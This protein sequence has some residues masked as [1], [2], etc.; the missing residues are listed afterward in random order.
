MS[1][2]LVNVND[3]CLRFDSFFTYRSQHIGETDELCVHPCKAVRCR[4][5]EVAHFLRTLCA[6]GA[7]HGPGKGRSWGAQSQ[8]RAEKKSY[9]CALLA[10]AAF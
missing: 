2:L 3:I 8:E 7:I 6:V 4:S 1:S 5:E 10:S 9:E